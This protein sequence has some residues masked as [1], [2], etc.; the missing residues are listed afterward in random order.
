VSPVKRPSRRPRT[1]YCHPRAV[2]ARARPGGVAK[3]L[4]VHGNQ[5]EA[6]GDEQGAEPLS[7]GFRM[8]DEATK[9]CPRHFLAFEAQEGRR[10][11]TC[12]C[13]LWTVCSTTRK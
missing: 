11:A 7:T 9:F 6:G 10:W 5:E 13:L 4:R 2:V 1:H 12:N 8:H 3:A